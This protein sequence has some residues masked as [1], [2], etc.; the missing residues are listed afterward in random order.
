[1]GKVCQKVFFLTHPFPVDNGV[2]YVNGLLKIVLL[3]VCAFKM[4]TLAASTNPTDLSGLCNDSVSV[5]VTTEKVPLVDYTFKPS[6][7]ILPAALIAT[8]VIGIAIDGM[9]DYHL[10]TRKDSTNF[11]AIDDYLEWG[12]FGWVFVCDLLGKEKHSFV[13]QLFL[14]GLAEGLNAGMV[15]GLKNVVDYTRPDGRRR[16][17][18]SGHTANAFLGAHLTFKEFKDSSPV[19][20]YSGYAMALLVAGSRVYKNRHWMADVIAGAGIGILSV[21]L[22]YLIYFPLRNALARKANTKFSKNLLVAPL[23]NEKGGGLYFSL[24]F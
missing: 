16:S 22:S 1:M 6:R 11:V 9:E 3:V 21:E 8:G 2:K 12:L 19:L 4:N 18:P 20:A 17:F 5:V 23:I 15:H 7:F 14:L 13:D 10:F 24:R